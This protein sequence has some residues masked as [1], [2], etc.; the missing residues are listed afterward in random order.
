MRASAQSLNHEPRFSRGFVL[1]G[2]PTGRAPVLGGFSR[3]FSRVFPWFPR[4]FQVALTTH[5]WQE[6]WQR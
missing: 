4:G 5:D 2:P 3:G 1:Q 6:G